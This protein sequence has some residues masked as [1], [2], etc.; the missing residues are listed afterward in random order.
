MK[1]IIA[2]LLSACI[3][4][5]AV[6][7]ALA[8]GK[9]DET[10]Y[11]ISNADGSAKNI[12]VSDHLTNPDGADT[13]ADV[14]EL[15]EIENVKG[16][17]TF[18]DGTWQANGNEIYYQGKSSDALPVEMK[19]SATLDGAE[20]APSEL[21][22]KSGHVVLH[23]EYQVNVSY[24]NEG[25]TVKVPFAVVMGTLLDNDVF[26]NVT[27]KNGCAVNDG[28]RTLA[29]GL[30]IPGIKAGLGLDDKDIELPESIEIEADAE[31]FSLPV[32]V[33]LA[34][35][36]AFAALDAGML[37]DA[38]SLK[39]TASKLTD[40]MT[41]LLDGENQLYNGLNTMNDGLSSLNDGVEQLASGTGTLA[42][43]ADTLA[44]GLTTLTDNNAA[45][46]SGAEQ[47]FET[48]L[49]QANAAL[50]Q[51]G[52]ETTL[53]IDNYASVLDTLAEAAST[54]A[55]TAQ[56]KAKVEEA[57]RAQEDTVRSAVTEAVRAQVEE[58]V[59]AAVKEQVLEQI[60]TSQNLTK[61][62]YEAAQK[63]GMIS[64]EQQKKL[65][66][67]LD[68]QMQSESVL[69][70]VAQQ[71]ESQMASD[72]V[73][74]L[75]EENTE[76]QVQLLVEQNMQSET[77]QA[78]IAAACEQGTSLVTLKAQ[79][80]SY[81]TFYSGLIAYTNGVSD[82]AAGAAQLKDGAVALQSGTAQLKDA[83]PAL[84]EGASSL[85]D[86][87]KALV[88]GLTEFDDE[89]VSKLTDAIGD[90]IEPLIA[91]VKTLIKAAQSYS[92]YSGLADGM[93]GAVRFIFRTDAIK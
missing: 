3:A 68:Q 17:E 34:T 89:A 33:S 22:G 24:E 71:T 86:G 36:E 92:N 23:I 61:E 70:I 54:D 87:A 66:A 26:S 59:T 77:V 28:D 74:A 5:M 18:S 2:I 55:V 40:A 47:V 81:N 83:M 84:T 90:E 46:V 85:V 53:T 72:T 58:Q 44:T 11:V 60:L 13:I 62:T 25:E 65:D 35:T 27:V 4:C 29:I 41:Q 14:S 80:D 32:T 91:N 63:S 56:A 88:D 50:T 51:A 82:A 15:E 10:V 49:A 8:E 73:T 75:I 42:T 43:G 12:I 20:I 6:L 67:A 57:V 93:D 48:L 39:E 69:A 52:V 76:N 38:E 31:N 37:D 45:L 64:A 79:L 30:C 9:K 7:P 1:R 78:Q 19:I 21:A 16:D